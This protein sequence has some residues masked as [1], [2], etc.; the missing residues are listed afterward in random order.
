MKTWAA[1]LRGNLSVPKLSQETGGPIQQGTWT[2][3]GLFSAPL[4][5]TRGQ[6]VPVLFNFGVLDTL[7]N[8]D[9]ATWWLHD[10]KRKPAEKQA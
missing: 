7:K 5:G 10:N 3:P 2:A 9:L 6:R 4:N 1:S 8:G